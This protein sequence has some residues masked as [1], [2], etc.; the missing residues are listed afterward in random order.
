MI[1]PCLHWSCARIHEHAVC[2]EVPR[3]R[4]TVCR[5]S[6]HTPSTRQCPPSTSARSVPSR[7]IS[8]GLRQHRP[9]RGTA[10]LTCRSIHWLVRGRNASPTMRDCFERTRRLKLV[11]RAWRVARPPGPQGC[12]RE[13]KIRHAHSVPQAHAP[14]SACAASLARNGADEHERRNLPINC[15]CS[16]FLQKE[17]R[18]MVS[19]SSKSIWTIVDRLP[20][21]SYSV[22]EY[23]EPLLGVQ[24]IGV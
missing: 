5:P 12:A 9:R 10:P 18:T 1:A 17:R 15:R 8:N 4:D 23:D 13:K 21:R 19:V 7:Q 6:K 3:A 2:A 14:G 22:L 16:I 24:Q 11:R 20:M